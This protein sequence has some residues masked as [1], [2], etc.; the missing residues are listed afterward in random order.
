MAG[1]NRELFELRD[2]VYLDF[3]KEIGIEIK[4]KIET[5]SLAIFANA[6]NEHF[7]YIEVHTVQDPRAIQVRRLQNKRNSLGGYVGE[8]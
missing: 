8:I 1:L 6:L 2:I 3:S 4:K 5:I 7:I